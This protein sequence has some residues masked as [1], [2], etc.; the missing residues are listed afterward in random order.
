MG[1]NIYF[2]KILVWFLASFFFKY[3][4]KIFY[5]KEQTTSARIHH[6]YL[7]CEPVTPFLCLRILSAFLYIF[8][9]GRFQKIFGILT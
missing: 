6:R 3:N 9:S 8:T 4:F 7:K 1:S 5:Q 2:I